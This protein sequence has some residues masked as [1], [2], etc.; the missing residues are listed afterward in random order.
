[1]ITNTLLQ[2]FLEQYA[3]Y[4]KTENDKKPTNKPYEDTLEGLI[5]LYDLI[6]EAYEEKEAKKYPDTAKSA[7][8]VE[9]FSMCLD[10]AQADFDPNEE[11]EA[12][13]KFYE[14]EED[15]LSMD[16]LF[17][18]YLRHSYLFMILASTRS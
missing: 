7:K 17:K 3:K 8:M 13:P 12:I 15:E 9:S 18:M 5:K 1:M 4:K 10:L 11:E 14:K 16:D 2:S 6:G